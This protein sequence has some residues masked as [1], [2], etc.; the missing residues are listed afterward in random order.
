MPAKTKRM[1][2]FMGLC[3]HSPKKAYG[4]CPPKEVAREFSHKPEGGY[5]KKDRRETTYY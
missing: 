3:A 1:Q 4:N 2:K 5:K